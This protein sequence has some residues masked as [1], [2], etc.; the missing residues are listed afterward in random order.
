MTYT[1]PLALVDFLPVFFSSLGLFLLARLVEGADQGARPLAYLG[2]ALVTLGG[3]SKAV[4]K[5]VLA[6]TGLNLSPLDQF[7]FV[8]LGPGFVMMASGL[9]RVRR[10]ER[11]VLAKASPWPVPSAICLVF[12]SVAAV[13]LVTAAGRRWS[14]VLLILT[15]IASNVT[16]VVAGGLLCRRKR[17]RTALLFAAN[18]VAALILARLARIDPQT[19]S[20]QWF[21]ET[22]NTFSQAGFAFASWKLA[23]APRETRSV[24]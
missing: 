23:T 5:L 24:S 10:A 11:G 19:I 3:L 21:E 1:V 4:W 20:L 12:L 14:T 9:L 6:T 22:L 8:F 17:Y 2:W 13:L 18:L 16:G 15:V 7:L